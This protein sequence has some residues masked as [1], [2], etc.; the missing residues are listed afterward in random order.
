MKLLVRLAFVSLSIQTAFAIGAGR[1]PGDTITNSKG[2]TLQFSV[3]NDIFSIERRLSP[4]CRT[5]RVTQTQIVGETQRAGRMMKW[6]ERWTLTGCGTQREY[7]IHFSFR[8]SVGSYKIDAP[9]A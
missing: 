4:A 8:G 1:L 7:L 6:D 3:S 2:T 5:P 9:R